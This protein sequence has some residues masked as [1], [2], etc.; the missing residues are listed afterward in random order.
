MWSFAHAARTGAVHAGEEGQDRFAVALSKKGIVL[1]VSDGAGSTKLGGIGAE[2]ACEAFVGRFKSYADSAAPTDSQVL[3]VVR[4]I[5]IAL[6]ERALELGAGME[7]LSCTLVGAAIGPKQ[8][9]FVQVGDGAGVLARRRKGGVNHEIA[10]WPS[11]GEAIN[12]TTF[13]TSANAEARLQVRRVPTPQSV[14]LFSDGIQYLVLDH[15][16]RQPHRPFF[17]A[18]YRQT[19]RQ[20]VNGG[21]E[22]PAVSAWL[23]QMLASPMVTTKTDD[24][25]CIVVAWRGA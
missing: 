21:G 22:E 17:D 1:C 14:T 4:A 9:T 12:E 3:D 15:A 25:T 19:E 2:V 23:A 11:E 20:S 5:R 13:L 6:G 24:D 8:A 10:V 18:V 16:A 7:E